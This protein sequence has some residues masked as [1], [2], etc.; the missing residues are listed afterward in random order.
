MKN[1]IKN[2]KKIGNFCEFGLNF[3]KINLGLLHSSFYFWSFFLPKQSLHKKC[4]ANFLRLDPDPPWERSLIRI[5]IE[6]ISPIRICKN[7]CEST[8]H[9]SAK[10]SPIYALTFK[11]ESFNLWLALPWRRSTSWILSTS[12]WSRSP[13]SLTSTGPSSGTTALSTL[14][15]KKLVDF[16]FYSFFTFD[17]FGRLFRWSFLLFFYQFCGSGSSKRWKSRFNKNL[18]YNFS[19]VNSVLL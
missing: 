8:F 19:P 10:F 14:H 17:C 6:K 11:F 13:P 15:S 18:I 2:S 9:S 7:E 1:K 16:S 3:L 4:C 12:A 5:C